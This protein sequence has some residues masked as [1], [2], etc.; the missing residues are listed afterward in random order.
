MDQ[1]GRRPVPAQGNQYPPSTS[2]HTQNPSGGHTYPPQYAS[3]YASAHPPEEHMQHHKGAFGAPLPQTAN[4]QFGHGAPAP[5]SRPLQGTFGRGISPPLPTSASAYRGYTES[6]YGGSTAHGSQYAHVQP[7]TPLGFSPPFHPEQPTSSR[8][9]SPFS[10]MNTWSMFSSVSKM[11]QNVQASQEYVSSKVSWFTGGF[12]LQLFQ[13][14]SSYVLKKMVMLMLPYLHKYDYV[15]AVPNDYV[16]TAPI[17]EAYRMEGNASVIAPPRSDL[18]A[19]DLY[20]PLLAMF[21]YVILAACNKFANG[22]FTPDVVHSM[23][24]RPLNM[25]LAICSQ[26]EW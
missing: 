14:D 21:T 23:V 7:G 20:I 18:Y 15:R 6:S 1:R 9:Q 13:V 2:Y 3:N 8:E 4:A 24:C 25:H 22:L 12:F 17:S 16:R 11:G 10:M 19:P 26:C 5:V